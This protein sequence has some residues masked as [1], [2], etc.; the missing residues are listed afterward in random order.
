VRAMVLAAGDGTRLGPLT[1]LMAKPMVE[2]AG[3]P[4]IGWIASW[5]CEHGVREMVVNLRRHPETL[6]AYLRDGRELGITTRFSLEHEVIGTGGALREAAGLLGDRFVLTYGDVLTDMNLGGLI[7]AHLENPAQPCLTLSL[8]RT[9]RPTECG[10]AS[11]GSDGRIVRFVEKPL[12]S[13]VFS[14]WANAGIMVIERRVLDFIPA[15]GFCD[16][17]S[18]VVPALIDAG[19]RVWGYRM[20]ASDYLIDMGTPAL[21]ERARQTWPTERFLAHSAGR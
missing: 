14:D 9:D 12:A 16:L 1:R 19:E 11:Q 6:L 18:E 8:I 20:S 5:L 15:G 2:V 13:D 10:I 4:A 17:S 3:R 7:A 21:L